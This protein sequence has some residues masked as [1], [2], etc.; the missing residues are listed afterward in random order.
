[1]QFEVNSYAKINSFLNV[2]RKRVDGYHEIYTH[3]E[4]LDLK[5]KL[6][7]LESSENKVFCDGIAP[8][9][10]IILKSIKW[11]NNKFSKNQHFSL[12]FWQIRQPIQRLYYSSH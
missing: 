2:L 7:F 6:F 4:L 8:E 5:D 3:F 11:F 1:M 10:N 12:G 9:E